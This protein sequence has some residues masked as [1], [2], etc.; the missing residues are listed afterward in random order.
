MVTL[1]YTKRSKLISVCSKTGFCTFMTDCKVYGQLSGIYCKNLILFSAAYYAVIIFISVKDT[2]PQNCQK[3][4]AKA[5][6]SLPTAMVKRV[7]CE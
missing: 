6:L 4:L 1:S 5:A 3:T 7:F 2:R